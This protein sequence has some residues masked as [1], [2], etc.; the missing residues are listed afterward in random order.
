MAVQPDTEFFVVIPLGGRRVY[1]GTSFGSLG[2]LQTERHNRFLGQ[3]DLG[4]ASGYF[5]LLMPSA[6]SFFATVHYYCC[7]AYKAHQLVHYPFL[8]LGNSSH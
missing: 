2:N 4:G 1:A 5:G 7:S 6:G 3:A 8:P